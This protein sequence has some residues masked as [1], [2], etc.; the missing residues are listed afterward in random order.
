[1][2]N[3]FRHTVYGQNGSC[4]SCM[5]GFSLRRSSDMMQ[6][7]CNELPNVRE[8]RI[9]FAIEFCGSFAALCVSQP[10]NFH[11]RWLA[12]HVRRLS[13]RWELHYTQLRLTLLSI[14]QRPKVMF[15]NGLL[16]LMHHQGPSSCILPLQTYPLLL[17]QCLLE[18]IKHLL[19]QQHNASVYISCLQKAH[20]APSQHH[21]PGPHLCPC[22]YHACLSPCGLFSPSTA[23]TPNWL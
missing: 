18:T 2:I 12:Q 23:A 19:I 5:L 10:F 6:Y 4:M 22:S 11:G 14:V 7:A 9:C 1:M 16:V 21:S 3:H 15:I 20:M 13:K 8:A 17:W